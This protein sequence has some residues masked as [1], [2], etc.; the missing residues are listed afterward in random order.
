MPDRALIEQLDQAIEALLAGAPTPAADSEL[1][2]LMEIASNLRDL[3]EESFMARLGTELERRASMPVS[4]T[5]GTTTHTV[6]PFISVA[7][8]TQLIEFMK[9]TFDAREL[10]RHPHRPGGGFVASVRIGDTDLLIMGDESLR[11]RE[12]LIALHVYVPDCDATYQR[13]LDAGAKSMGEPQDTTYGE[14]AGFVQDPAGNH[15]YI[16]THLGPTPALENLWTVTPFVH[17][18]DV[19][20]YIE[21]LQTAMGAVRL[22]L[23]E[24][25]G[26]VVYAA[27]R[28]GDAVV[29]MGERE[30]S[31]KSS[32]YWYVDDVDAAYHRALSAG[33]I[34][35]VP[36]ADQPFGD[37]I[38][39]LQD[40]FGFQWIAAKHLVQE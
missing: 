40:P 37:R 36:P 24:H 11:G 20:K 34:S 2:D 31:L 9:H 32:F 27:V 12:S 23:H 19:K 18:V 1:S 4:S 21:F 39:I 29:E 3:P 13:A 33:A 7:D 10:S 6:T 35:I 15:W 25:S 8:G 28:I 17:H 30:S 22:A 26:R 5:T 16:A 38:A 14:R